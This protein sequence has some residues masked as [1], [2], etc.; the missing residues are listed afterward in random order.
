[1]YSGIYFRLR[2]KCFVMF[3]GNNFLSQ[4]VSFGIYQGVV[5]SHDKIHC[6]DPSKQPRALANLWMLASLASQIQNAKLRLHLHSAFGFFNLTSLSEKLGQ[7]ATV[8][9]QGPDNCILSHE[10]TTPWQIPN[11]TLWPNK[12]LPTNVRKKFSSQS[13]KIRMSFWYSFMEAEWF[14]PILQNHRAKGLRRCK[15]LVSANPSILTQKLKQGMFFHQKNK[16]NQ[17]V[18]SNFENFDFWVVPTSR[19]ALI[20]TKLRGID[21]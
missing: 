14:L 5:F 4:M 20:L 18:K 21:F 17:G 8:V 19:F 15:K 10:K 2:W 9:F 16:W 12:L 3:G 13:P 11:E 6:L 7:I 1:M